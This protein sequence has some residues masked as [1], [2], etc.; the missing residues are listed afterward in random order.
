MATV[1]NISDAKTSSN[2]GDVLATY[3][4]GSCIGLTLYDPINRVGGMLHYQLPS[5]AMDPARAKERPLMFAD[6]GFEMLLN[7]L[8]STGAVKKRLKVKIAGAAQIL[9][10][11]GVFNIGRR[12]HAAIRKVLWQHGMLIDAEDVGGSVPRNLYLRIADGQ[13]T[14]RSHTHERPL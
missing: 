14:V 12:N 2:P 6:T 11:G 10:D 1:V 9:D 13:V 8:L 7:R 3:S 5:A 4:L